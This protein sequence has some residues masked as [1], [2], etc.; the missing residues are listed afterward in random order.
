M[1]G[2]DNLPHHVFQ[3]VPLKL[4]VKPNGAPETGRM[5]AHC[6]EGRCAAAAAAAIGGHFCAISTAEKAKNQQQTPLNTA[7]LTEISL[8]RSGRPTQSSRGQSPGSAAEEPASNGPS[9]LPTPPLSLRMERDLLLV[10]L[11]LSVFASKS[12][13]RKSGQKEADV[14]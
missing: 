6:R 12:V 10:G 3:T 13:C 1:Q 8:C 5:R 2:L 14:L 4:T 11:T 7:Y 9:F